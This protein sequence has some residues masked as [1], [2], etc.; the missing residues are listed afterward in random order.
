[1]TNLDDIKRVITDAQNMVREKHSPRASDCVCRSM[2]LYQERKWGL[3]Y[4]FALMAI[5]HS[6][7]GV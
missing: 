5:E 7:A 1:M 3:A 6:R 4:A 2:I